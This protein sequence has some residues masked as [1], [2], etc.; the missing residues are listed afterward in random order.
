MHKR[1]FTPLVTTAVH[2]CLAQATRASSTS[3]AVGTSSS[4]AALPSEFREVGVA[5]NTT[6]P[7]AT[8]LDQLVSMVVGGAAVGVE[9]RRKE[10]RPWAMGVT[11]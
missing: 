10:L 8:S 9:E 3:S 4:T 11:Q 5:K 2:A 6:V 1:F 7:G